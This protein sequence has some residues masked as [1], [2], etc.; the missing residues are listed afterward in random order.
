MRHR[1]RLVLTAWQREP[2]LDGDLRRPAR[3][4]RLPLRRLPGEEFADVAGIR[5]VVAGLVPKGGLGMVALL[6]L[7]RPGMS[8]EERALLTELGYVFQLLDDLHDLALD[9]AEGIT[10][11]A[12]LNAFS[13]TGLAT[14]IQH[15]RSRFRTHYGTASP[16]TAHLA[17][18][19]VGAPLAARRR[20]GHHGRPRP[21]TGS[22]PL[23]F[24]RAG[25]IRPDAPNRTR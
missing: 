11:S 7:L 2:E 8:E 23:L 13:L 10:T 24:S 22:L 1:Q 6:S 9:R 14:R 4:A 5:Q 19:L 18:T 12:T 20:A 3:P 15:L 25:N 17:L 16:L 21:R